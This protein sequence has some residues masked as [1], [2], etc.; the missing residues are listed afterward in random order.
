MRPPAIPVCL[1]VAGSDSGGGAGIQADLRT[2][3]W[4]GTYGASVITAITA[5]SPLAVTGIHAVPADMVV[6]QLAAVRD[7]YDLAAIKTGMLLDAAIIRAV[8]GALRASRVPLVVDPV[9]V[10]TSGA[11]LLREDAVTALTAALLPLATIVTPN[12]PEAEILAGRPIADT[13][14]LRAAASR[15]AATYRGV[16]LKGG[17]LAAAPGTDLLVV[18]DRTYELTAPVL[19]DVPTTHG[20]GCTFSAAI[21]ANLAL[22]RSLLDAVVAAKAFVWASLRNPRALGPAVSGLCP[23]ADLDLSVVQVRIC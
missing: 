19:R 12:L 1:T 22:G 9:M 15:L 17:H 6:A 8:A 7:A 5:Q 21:A 16:L 4:F 14:G 3:N 10:A 23:P 18:G 20:T 2:F 13:A 11:R